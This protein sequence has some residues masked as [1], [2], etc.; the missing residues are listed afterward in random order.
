[1]GLIEEKQKE[2][3]A[4]L[5]RKQ[6]HQLEYRNF[7]QALNNLAKTK[8]GEIVLRHIAKISGFFQSLTVVKGG[9]GIMNGIDPEGMLVNSGRR[10]LYLDIRKPMSEETRRLIESKPTEEEGEENA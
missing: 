3:K 1:M 4:R 5:E 7:R 6:K 10:D 8:D 9:N 2:E